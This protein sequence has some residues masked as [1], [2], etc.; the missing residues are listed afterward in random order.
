MLLLLL[1]WRRC[2][3]WLWSHRLFM[4]LLSRLFFLNLFF[5]SN[6]FWFLKFLWLLLFPGLSSNF[7]DEGIHGISRGLSINFL[8][9]LLGNLDHRSLFFFDIDYRFNDLNL[10][11]LWI[12]ICIF[13]FPVNFFL[14]FIFLIFP[15]V[16][17]HMFKGV[18]GK[19]FNIL[20]CESRNL[21]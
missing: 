13:G 9:L 14:L 5:L 12:N 6:H 21:F 17:N 10:R 11:N 15:G 18:L 8:L 20:Y 19:F 7:L 3:S 1:L 4:R 2:R 16:G